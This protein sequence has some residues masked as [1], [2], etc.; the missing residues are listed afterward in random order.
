[1]QLSKI[2]NI[3]KPLITSKGI[4]ASLGDFYARP[5]GRDTYFTLLGLIYSKADF[6]CEY[7]SE[8]ILVAASISFLQYMSEEGELPHE[9]GTKK[10]GY[11]FEVEENGIGRHF[12]SIDATGLA[13]L[14]FDELL[15]LYSTN[16]KLSYIN[17]ELERM[18]SWSLKTYDK[19]MN[20][21]G[22]EHRLDHGSREHTWQDGNYSILTDSGTL[23]N[24]PI[25]TVLEQGLYWAVFCRYAKRLKKVNAD[26][27][28]KC[29]R[30]AQL[31]KE[32]FNEKF[33]FT[34]NEK[35]SIARA[36][37]ADNTVIKSANIDVLVCLGFTFEEESILNENNSE[38][39]DEII[40]NIKSELDTDFGFRNQGIYSPSHPKLYYHGKE[41]IWPFINILAIRALK[42]HSFS[43]EAYELGKKIKKLLEYFKTP[44]E[45]AELKPDNT[46]KLYSE[47]REDGTK[48][49]S[50]KTQAWT[51]GW[52]HWLDCFL[53]LGNN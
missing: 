9:V 32:S 35:L 24:H 47:M 43:K 30:T 41:T 4:N 19:K 1:M 45:V 10:Q 49:I 22:Y 26:L 21:M 23:P 53:R 39:I 3:G 34:K 40:N 13:L 46:I 12:G 31:L 42:V 20:L 25:Y 18:L 14:A 2:I 36:V 6:D 52:G 50:S 33:V 29:Y 51:V 28:L 8:D 38:R 27:S 37:T 16:P 15:N 7:V 48:F 5:F 44:I 17:A 11:P